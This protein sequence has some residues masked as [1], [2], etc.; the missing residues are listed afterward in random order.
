MESSQLS[1]SAKIKTTSKVNG[2]R[3]PTGI[4]GFDALI[5]GGIP[6][7]Y[8]GERKVWE[9]NRSWEEPFI[10]AVLTTIKST[11]TNE[12]VNQEQHRK[13]VATHD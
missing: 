1:H 9:W 5:E 13:S 10:I 4:K 3:V 2:D 12:N 11:R 6:K 7:G 8:S